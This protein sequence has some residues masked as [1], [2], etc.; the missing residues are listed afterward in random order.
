MGPWFPTC[1]ARTCHWPFRGRETIPGYDVEV[2][3]SDLVIRVSYKV[4]LVDVQH[5][6]VVVVAPR[7]ECGAI[8]VFVNAAGARVGCRAVHG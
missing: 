3:L 6:D 2:A 1:P 7:V 8:E 5:V 4:W